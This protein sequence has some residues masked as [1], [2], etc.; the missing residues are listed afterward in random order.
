MQ[1]PT[2]KPYAGANSTALHVGQLTLYFSYETVIAFYSP[3]TRLVVSENLWGA[4]T[5]KHIKAVTGREPEKKAVASG[6]YRRLARPEFETLLAATVDK[7]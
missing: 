4:T 7:F 2:I 1:M 5:A 6:A 3:E